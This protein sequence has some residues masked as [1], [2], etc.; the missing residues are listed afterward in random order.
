MVHADELPKSLKLYDHSSLSHV[1]PVFVIATKL[2]WSSK[3][4]RTEWLSRHKQSF[5][6]VGSPQYLLAIRTDLTEMRDPKSIL[7]I[8]EESLVCINEFVFPSTAF[9]ATKELSVDD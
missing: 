2:P 4:E 9:D 6:S 3:S 1:L 8:G 5:G 7:H